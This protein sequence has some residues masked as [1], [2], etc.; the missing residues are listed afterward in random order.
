M[1]DYSRF[2][3]IRVSAG[4]LRRMTHDDV[5]SLAALAKDGS[6]FI[7]VGTMDSTS[8]DPAEVEFS[9]AA[10]RVMTPAQFDRV[11]QMVAKSGSRMVVIHDTTSFHEGLGMLGFSLR[12]IQGGIDAAGEVST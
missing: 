3:R 4:A 1:T 6:N 5:S 8:T 2:N 7:Q 10:L 11:V 12:G 9:A